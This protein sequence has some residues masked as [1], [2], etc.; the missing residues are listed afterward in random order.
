MREKN[1]CA[2]TRTVDNPYEVWQSADG[3]WT[4]KLLKKYQTPSKEAANRYA[5]WLVSVDSPF[6]TGEMGDTYVRD[7][8]ENAT[9][10]WFDEMI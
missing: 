3:S 7:I 4:W 10:L 8:K 9:R 5:R 2:K 1:E 6:V